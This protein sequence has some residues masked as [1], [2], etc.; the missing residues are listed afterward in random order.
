MVYVSPIN[1]KSILT[2]G[3]IDGVYVSSL[4]HYPD[5][6]GRLFKAYAEGPAP[7]FPVA[8]NTF[9]HFFTES[10]KDVFRGM[11]FQGEPHSAAKVITIVKGAATDF[12]IDLRENSPTFGYLQIEPLS[13]VVPTSIYIP[14]GVAHGYIS[15]SSGTIIS[16]RQDVAFCGN[17]DGG[18]SGEAVSQYLPIDFAST[19]RSER[20][21]DLPILK[22]LEFNSRC[23]K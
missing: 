2:L 21:R 7:S 16:Y 3:S 6:R 8:F 23:H 15:L 14:Q 22:N 17:C 9:E 10:K 19:I 4:P 13:E 20:D 1:S 11:H 18:F 12:L 5:V